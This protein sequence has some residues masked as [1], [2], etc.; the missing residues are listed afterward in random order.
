MKKMTLKNLQNKFYNS[1]TR[2]KTCITGLI[3]KKRLKHAVVA[4]AASFT[5]LLF[6]YTFQKAIF[7]HMIIE[8]LLF[9]SV[10]N[11]VLAIMTFGLIYFVLRGEKFI[12]LQDTFTVFLFYFF[13][14]M[15][16]V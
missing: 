3:D 2:L 15:K 8:F 5:S 14:Q 1:N 4:I 12:D 10:A 11:F 6:F 13:L 9:Y 16:F 7:T